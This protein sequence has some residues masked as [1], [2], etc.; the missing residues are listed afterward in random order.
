MQ[1]VGGLVTAGRKKQQQVC[2][3]RRARGGQDAQRLG[4]A[5]RPAAAENSSQGVLVNA[6]LAGNVATRPPARLHRCQQ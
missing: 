5:G 2:V 1:P 6:G 3:G 4:K